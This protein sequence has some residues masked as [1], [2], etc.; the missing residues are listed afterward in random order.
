MLVGWCQGIAP[1]T[2][3]RFVVDNQSEG[4]FCSYEEVWPSLKKLKKKKKKKILISIIGAAVQWAYEAAIVLELPSQLHESSLINSM[5]SCS[6]PYGILTVVWSLI[7]GEALQ[8][9]GFGI[10][11]VND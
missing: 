3:Y 1:I 5:V 10:V 8:P 2:T 4:T 7:V 9:A 6:L 11:I